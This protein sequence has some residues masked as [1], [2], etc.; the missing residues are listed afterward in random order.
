MALQASLKS[1]PIV[2]VT[3]FTG[4]RASRYRRLHELIA[5][6]LAGSFSCNNV[7]S[8]TPKDRERPDC[9]TRSNGPCR[10]I[11]RFAG[12]KNGFDAFADRQTVARLVEL[13]RG[14]L[15]DAKHFSVDLLSGGR[16]Q[17]R[18]VNAAGLVRL[19]VAKQTDHAGM[20]GVLVEVEACMEA[21]R[22]AGNICRQ[23]KTAMFA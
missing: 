1:L 7:N 17:E 20:A 9:S 4:L 15:G 10:P 21:D 13:D 5:D 12:G 2:G 22:T 3:M 14:I 6:L 19:D 16:V 8:P 18:A 23:Y 11:A